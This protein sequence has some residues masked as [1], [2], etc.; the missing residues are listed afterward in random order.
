M[1]NTF[2]IVLKLILISL[3]FIAWNQQ[4]VKAQ[5]QARAT[6]IGIPQILPSPYISDFEQNVFAGNYQVQLNISG[7][8]PVDVRFHVRLTLNHEVL[9]DEISL[10]STFSSGFH[11]LSPF[12]DFVEFEATTRA[13]LEQLPGNRFRQ[14]W[15]TGSFP[16]GNYSITIQP[17]IVGSQIP[18]I[19][20]RANFTVRYPQPP[21]LVTP[22]N[23]TVISEAQQTPIFAWSPVM[24]PAGMNVEYEFY[25]VELFDGQ[26]PADGIAGNREHASTVRPG[27]SMI[28]YTSDFL[29]LEKGK[30]YAWQVTALDVNNEIPIK[31]EGQ[32][33][34]FVFTY[35]EEEEEQDEDELQ[36]IVFDTPE[37]QFPE[38]IPV[39]TISGEAQ[40]RFSETEGG[41]GVQPIYPDA[42]QDMQVTD[43]SNVAAAFDDP[44]Y[45]FG[46]GNGFNS[47]ISIQQTGTSG[48]SGIETQ[49]D[50]DNI[51]G[52]G[53]NVAPVFGGGSTGAKKGNLNI[54]PEDM[55]QRLADI[56]DQMDVHP[57]E[58]GKVVAEFVKE[59][60]DRTTLAS[61]KVDENGRFTL[62]LVP[63]E[64]A[65]LAVTPSPQTTQTSENES[66]E[67]SNQQLFSPGVFNQQTF[68]GSNIDLSVATIT[69][70]VSHR[71]FF[72]VSK[73]IQVRTNNPRN[74]NTGIYQAKPKTYRLEPTVLAAESGEP[75]PDATVEVFRR[76]DWYDNVPAVKPEG[77]PLPNSSQ[78]DE[79]MINNRM[80]TKVAEAGQGETITRLFT[81]SFSLDR[82]TVRVNAPG[83]EPYITHLLTRA[84]PE[85]NEILTVEK[86]YEL[87]E[88]LPVVEG[89]VVRADNQAPVADV[90]V[91][92][93]VPGSQNEGMS[94][95]SY[96]ATT[97]RDGH[98]TISDIPP[99]DEPYELV[100]SGSN[101]GSYSE[102]LLLN[103]RGVSVE[104]D[105]I[106]LD[107]VL[108][109]VVG[110]I[111]NDE[112]DP[113]SNAMIR[114]ENGG[115]PV[116][117]DQYGR[118]VTANTEGIHRLQVRKI[119]HRDLDT[120]ITVQVEED[121]DFSY[122]TP[123]YSTDWTQSISGNI[124]N[125][126]TQWAEAINST[127]TFQSSGGNFAP[128]QNGFSGNV[129]NMFNV[130][131]SDIENAARDQGMSEVS[132]QLNEVSSYLLYLMGDQGAPG[133]IYDAGTFTLNR[134]VG[135]LDVMV[136]S[137]LNS[138]PVPDA[139]VSVGTSGTEGTTDNNGSVYFGEAPGG[140][141]SLH[142]KPSSA[143]NFVPFTTEV[144]ISDNGDTTSVQ[145]ELELGGRAEGTVMAAGNP[146]ED[147]TIRVVG[148]DDIETTTDSNGNYSLPGI[149]TGEWTLKATRSG[150]VGT[151]QTE[152]FTE[153]Q[154]E[155]VNFDLEDA[156][157]NIA[158]L[159]GFEI[160]VDEL[161][162]A[163]D[164]TIT[165][166]FVSLSSNPLFEVSDRQR[167]PFSNIR[168][169]EENGELKPTDGEVVTD[170]SE[171]DAQVFD[172]LH[173]VISSEDGLTVRAR[174]IGSAG[175]VA[176][177]VEIDYQST[178]TSATGWEWPSEVDQFVTL[179][180]TNE[181]P[182]DIGEEELVTV[183][184]DGSFPFPD[185]GIPDF[186]LAFGSA[187]ETISLY[188]FD[189]TLSLNE[190]VLRNDGFHMNGDVELAGIPL[191]DDAMITLEELWIGTDGTVREANIDLDPSP[192]LALSDWKM[193]LISGALSETGFS[194]GGA[195]ELNIPGSDP[196]DITFS[197]LSISPD[198]LFG[199]EFMFPSAGIDVFG[200]VD[201]QSRPGTDISFGKV[202]NED[203]YFV[204]GAAEISLPKYVDDELVFNNFLIRTDGE[205]S[206]NIA[207]NFE[208]DFF[209]LA[210]LSVTGVEFRNTGTPEI[211]VD[212]Q[213]GLRNIPFITAQAGGLTYQPGGSVSFDEIDLD[214]D[215]VGVAD[216]GA[217][218]GLV[219][220]A[221]R[222]G[223]SGGG[224]LGITNTDIDVDI[225]FFYNKIQ[226]TS[227]GFEIGANIESGSAIPVGN[228]TIEEVSGG[229]EYNTSNTDFL[230]SLGGSLAV[231]PN[232]GHAASLDIDVTVQSGPVIEGTADL[233]VMSED[234][235]N[236]WL[237]L[238]F[239]N[240]LF[241]VEAAIGF[242]KLEGINIDADASTMM[243]LSG[244]PGNTYW[245]TG[246]HLNAS[247]V[248]LFDTNANILAA[249][250]LPNQNRFQVGE[251]TQVERNQSQYT[252]FIRNDEDDFF[253]VGNTISGV[254]MGVEVKIGVPKNDEKEFP[255]GIGRIYGH[256]Y[257]ESQ[258][259]FQADFAG[260]SIGLYLGSYWEA[261]GGLDLFGFDMIEINGTASGDITGWYN[262]GIWTAEGGANGRIWGHIGACNVGCRTKIC[263]NKVGIPKGG[264]ACIRAGIDIEYAS[265]SGLDIDFS[266]R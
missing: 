76:S 43:N 5:T 132:D 245:M 193:E 253:D 204:T 172:F 57:L 244:E 32:S 191:L 65:A 203:I 137:E 257:N 249:W 258:C 159:L 15:Q 20:G 195:V 84:N 79:E 120:T 41:V 69:I 215:I 42:Y 62:S 171:M 231:A 168:V 11:L 184:S 3:I 250:N 178:F 170:V 30:T 140:T 71:S 230:V 264:S 211:Y 242:N 233:N 156:G 7:P 208:A 129:G 98:F 167:L 36:P 239:P 108:V 116:Q 93:H 209:E 101:I 110:Q 139:T 256:M 227:N 91:S 124:K 1:K 213:F 2:S 238:D 186:E 149:P 126:T 202:Q 100:V 68:T 177:R 34:I 117:T 218:I 73:E 12:S 141:V 52:A 90:P 70:T 241:A 144:T 112:G 189:V 157:F 182:D 205:F 155:T 210:D 40:F 162:T 13:I 67:E 262:N 81:A 181:L 247:L 161:S 200:I 10:P 130:S 29:P 63:S 150:Y 135:R 151:S 179:P 224:S 235:A 131:P 220:T 147:A 236:A 47:S 216:V 248:N 174:E 96:L 6:I 105:P 8:G 9:V 152:T 49:A 95:S 133:G 85:E 38:A 22:A 109:S 115:T 196:T 136:T 217:G 128:G 266:R 188:G 229:F 187:S 24:G 64:I 180:N 18:G 125:S 263:T 255:F 146:V 252:Q 121:P 56:V 88:S 99:R 78:N 123:A 192:E 143:T 19:E 74:Y 25:M 51:T 111:L 214:F 33:E 142:V 54:V 232:T 259:K 207:A 198:Q 53:G 66:I 173:V 164:T 234:I 106:M 92:L 89:R 212:G 145:I 166:A 97:D 35:G 158:S 75:I 114:W 80:H 251:R 77:W 160:E 254:F 28:P 94:I 104:R 26:S 60:G 55:Q 134:S 59:N 107:P 16:E 87:L 175:Y 17:Q 221:T 169:F 58:G 176:G 261:G 265:N 45:Q 199:G 21:S 222:Q 226:N 219:D 225:D 39:T 122:Q 165:G 27:T 127:S 206:A 103:E 46:E 86:T 228:F 83:Y 113:V 61:T 31:N 223:F 118:F 37:P 246:A 4:E 185:I 237:S 154:A 14:S 148:R 243:V 119:A 82:Y 102:E 72:S 163:S 48:I 260:N 153:D 194:F 240:S 44:N 190:S 23:G 201:L 197:D 183:T 50:L 138:D